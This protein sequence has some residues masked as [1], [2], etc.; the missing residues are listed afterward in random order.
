MKKQILL[1]MLIGLF[2]VT[3]QAQYFFSNFTSP[4]T[5]TTQGT[6]VFGSAWDDTLRT[7]AVPFPIS[8]YG[9][10]YD[11]LFVESNGNIAFFNNALDFQNGVTDTVPVV[12]PLGGAFFEGFNT[13]LVSLPEVSQVSTL[14]TG[15]AGNRVYTVE[16]KNVG[17]Y[18]NETTV[19]NFQ[20]L[21]YEADGAVEFRYGS[22]SNPSFVS[23]GPYIGIGHYS[24]AT[25]SMIDTEQIFI[26]GTPG[27]PVASAGFPTFST[28]P[29]PNTVFRFA[30]TPN[31]VADNAASQFSLYPNPSNGMLFVNPAT[32]NL[33]TIEL[34]DQ[35]GKA[36][37]TQNNLSGQ[38]TLN[39]G[40]VANGLYLARITTKGMQTIQR[41]LLA[42]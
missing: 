11:S 36:I 25:S 16:W 23:N 17:S 15:N 18:Y 8:I 41:I 4:Y 22:S 27:A 19:F 14:L 37:L 39:L 34:F 28:I 24:F 2:T 13:D 35:T 12:M 10:S 33:Y 3:A 5:N 7:F 38:Q 32:A 1:T 40:N 29:S 21:F 30:T 20:A 31:S 26:N 9:Q 42:K 6:D